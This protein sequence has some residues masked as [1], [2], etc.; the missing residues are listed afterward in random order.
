[1]GTV[2]GVT[3]R[4]YYQRGSL[5]HDVFR[6]RVQPAQ[7]IYDAFQEE[8]KKRKGRDFEVW[9][10]EELCAVWRAAKE[11]AEQNGLRVPTM[12]EVK[13]ADTYAMGSVDYGAK[14]SYRVV[15]FMKKG[16]S[17]GTENLFGSAMEDDDV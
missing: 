6:P 16:D 11:Y 9:N 12:E 3:L 5:M 10:T 7:M 13:R 4:N 2:I 1:M 14:L 17:D 15:E 8:A